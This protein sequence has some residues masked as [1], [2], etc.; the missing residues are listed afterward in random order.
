MKKRI[1]IIDDDEQLNKINEK[2]LLSS[3][4]VSELHIT[5][6]GKDALDYLST[7]IEKGYALPHIIITD[8]DM[9][10]V[11]G[12]EF[13]DAFHRLDFSGKS[14]MELV[15]FTGSSNPKDRQKALARGIRHYIPKPYLL[16]P[17]RDIVAHMRI[18]DTDLFDNRKMFG[19]ERTIL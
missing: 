9:P 4:L 18:E 14:A 10:V 11:D 19:L 5:R 12:F 16:R 17:L 8:L 6:N 3:G 7:R 2:I 15:V 13:I 1:L